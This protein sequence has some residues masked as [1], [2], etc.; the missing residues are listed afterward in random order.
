MSQFLTGRRP[1]LLMGLL[2]LALLVLTVP[3]F[4][5]EPPF[6]D[7]DYYGLAARLVRRGMVLERDM[8]FMAPPG[9]VWAR[10]TVDSL[11]GDRHEVLKLV[12]LAI[13]LASIA[14]ITAWVGRGLG[15]AH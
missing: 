9:L 8:R 14:L 5:C 15:R 7:N 10:A 3:T 13:A 11:S 2:L 12:D 1:A 4:V 6:L